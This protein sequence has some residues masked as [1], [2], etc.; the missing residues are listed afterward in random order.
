MPVC[1]QRGKL[2]K[3]WFIALGLAAV[4]AACGGGDKPQ[5]SSDTED[6][7]PSVSSSSGGDTAADTDSGTESSTGTDTDSD[8]PP[9]SEIERP[10][11]SGNAG[12]VLGEAARRA[13]DIESLRGEFEMLMNL[14]GEEVSITGE[15]A[16]QAPDSMYLTM[17]FEGET[18]EMLVIAPDVYVNVPGEGWQHGSVEDLG[19]DFEDF[20]SWFDNRSLLDLDELAGALDGIEDLGTDEIDGETY[21]HFG[22]QL[23]LGALSDA[24]PG[25]TFDDETFGDLGDAIE[26][27]SFEFWIDGDSGLLRR[28]ALHL[29]MTAPFLGPVEVG[30]N[31]DFLDYNGDVDIPAP[32]EDAAPLSLE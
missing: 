25:G 12:E 14:G 2:V 13:Q 32:P 22:G 19:A 8:S 11:G 17:E 16:F 27:A 1:K 7:A 10:A 24:L 15:M 18:M 3:H 21:G 26:D 31:M 4:L 23:D 29:E 30:M 9:A 20:Q 6:T 28:L 5:S